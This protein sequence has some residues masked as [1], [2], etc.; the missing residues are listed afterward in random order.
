MSI[1]TWFPLSAAPFP[2][3]RSIKVRN[4]GSNVKLQNKWVIVWYVICHLSF[5]QI[6]AFLLSSSYPMEQRTLSVL[7]WST[8]SVNMIG[9]IRLRN[10]SCKS[11]WLKGGTMMLAFLMLSINKKICRALFLRE[12][13]PSDCRHMECG[14]S[15]A[16]RGQLRSSTST[17]AS[18]VRYELK[19]YIFFKLCI[20]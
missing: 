7:V 17:E 5:H 6:H 14:W 8:K 16:W 4:I 15:S 19:I 2:V 9:E 1:Q 12:H 3:T 18:V 20:N 11:Y 13:R 10:D